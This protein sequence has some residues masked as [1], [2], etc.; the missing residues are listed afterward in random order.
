MTSSFMAPFTLNFTFNIHVRTSKKHL[1]E[2]FELDLG[3]N[4]SKT[5]VL[6]P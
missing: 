4:G 1:I 6:A 3:E 2:I 5:V